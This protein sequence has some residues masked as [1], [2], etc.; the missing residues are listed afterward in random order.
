M[1]FLLDTEEL[2]TGLIIFRRADVKHDEF[3]CRAKVPKSSRYKIKSLDTASVA[4]ARERAFEFD[5]ELRTCIKH[6]VP[7]FNRPFSEVAEDYAKTQREK[8]ETGEISR[9]RVETVESA[10]RTLNAYV[11]SKQI[12][13][14]TQADWD[15]YSTWRHKLGKREREAKPD[16]LR[17]RAKA[18]APIAAPE[19][20]EHEPVS[21]WT[22][23]SD[24]S[25]FRAVMAYAA[26]RKYVSASQIFKGRLHAADERREEFTREEYRHLHTYARGWIK[27]A[28][29]PASRWYREMVYYFLLVMCNT[30]MRPAEAKNLCWR[31][32]SFRN[33]WKEIKGREALTEEALKLAEAAQA[34]AKKAE[35][36]KAKAKKAGVKPAD[37]PPDA[38]KPPEHRKIAVLSV[39]GKDKYR[40]LVAPDNVVDYLER[41]RAIAKATD[42]D[43]FVFTNIKGKA[44]TTLYKALVK[45]LLKDAKLLTGPEG[46]QRTTYCFRH[47]YATLRL[48]EGVDVYLLAEQMGTSV[49]MIEDHYG[50]INPVKNADRILMG[51]HVWETQPETEEGNGTEGTAAQPHSRPAKSSRPNPRKLPARRN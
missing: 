43:D 44:T 45:E 9:K 31:D 29:T 41:I 2:K 14:V 50:H 5:A 35:A 3:Y 7:I 24:M 26:S 34:E 30:G 47:T 28:E 51:M 4:M 21:N 12:H 49:Q 27:R 20:K 11:G 32:V 46:S 13:V 17:R 38:E 19:K 18:A 23:R 48:S 25:V 15:G 40:N 39:R 33:V 37:A 6:D 42:P 10:I 36:K 1:A 16:R 8:A 22:I